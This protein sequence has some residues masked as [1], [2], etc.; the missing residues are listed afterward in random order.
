VLPER[1]PRV[2]NRLA[3]CWSDKV[4]TRRLFEELLTDQRGGRRGFP[5]PVRDELLRLRLAHSQ[6]DRESASR[7]PPPIEGSRTS[8]SAGVPWAPGRELPR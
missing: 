5:P 6:P 3:L 1:Y 8:V 4:L 2:A 7:T